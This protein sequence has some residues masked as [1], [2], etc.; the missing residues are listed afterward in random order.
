MSRI[1]E[2]ESNGIM[3][4]QENS[5]RIDG[6]IPVKPLLVRRGELHGKSVTVLKDDR[7]NTNVVS[8]EFFQK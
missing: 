3:S 1:S 6:S 7:C 8:K 2:V 5:I 4:S